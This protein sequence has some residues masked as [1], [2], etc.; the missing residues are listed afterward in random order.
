MATFRNTHSAVVMKRLLAFALG[1]VLVAAWCLASSPAAGAFRMEGYLPDYRISS[2]DPSMARYLTGVIYFSVQVKPTGE[3][4]LTRMPPAAISKL[5]DLK[6]RYHVRILIAVGGWNR[7][8]GLAEMAVSARARARFVK[9]LADLCFRNGFDGADFDWEQ[10]SAAAEE[11][12]YAQ[13]LLEAVCV[14]HGR[15]MLLSVSITPW[16]KLPKPVLGALDEVHVMSYDHPGRHSTLNQAASDVKAWEAQGVPA[17]KLVLGVPAYGR[18]VH[19]FD[20][21]MGYADIVHKYHP[22]PEADE[23]GGFSFN[24][25]KTVQA[26]VWFALGKELGGFAL[27]ELG[28]DT[29]DQTSLVRAAFEAVRRATSRRK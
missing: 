1:I 29:T 13:L 20:Q 27:W 12:G 28:Q 23:A 21:V 24:G 4:D 7:S 8:Q 5:K 14:F 18:N 11:R 3:L 6:R 25:I 26:K 15:H 16:Q 17:R 19:K 2:F 10:F 9:A 22:A